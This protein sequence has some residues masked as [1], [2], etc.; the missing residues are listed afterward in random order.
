M[1]RQPPLD[2]MPAAMRLSHAAR[3]LVVAV[4]VGVGLALIIAA[5]LGMVALLIRTAVGGG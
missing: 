5:V 2:A 4:I 3:L 1:G